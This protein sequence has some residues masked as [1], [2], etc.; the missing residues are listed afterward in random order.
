ML[1]K[2]QVYRAPTVQH[3]GDWF[4]SA[5]GLL[6]AARHPPHHWLHLVD[7][8][9]WLVTPGTET[10]GPSKGKLVHVWEIAV[11]RS[12]LEAWR[13][14]GHSEPPERHDPGN[15][16]RFMWAR[17]HELGPRRPD[18]ACDLPPCIK[19]A[20]FE[21]HA[22][23]DSLLRASSTGVD[24]DGDETVALAGA[25]AALGYGRSSH[26]AERLGGDDNLTKRRKL[27]RG[28]HKP[29]STL[30]EQQHPAQL[31]ARLALGGGG[32]E[33]QHA[34]K[35]ELLAALHPDCPLG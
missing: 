3:I 11:R 10:R 4:A 12:S 31:S 25:A 18:Q 27:I 26:L 2:T 9:V 22:V 21:R 35:L 32:A 20:R 24:D 34:V 1:S 29:P 7:V 33:Q 16:P 30:Q 19:N 17:T 28:T 23:W 8:V 6:H 14:A 5:D 13:V 15:W